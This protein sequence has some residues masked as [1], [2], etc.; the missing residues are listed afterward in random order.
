MTF[1]VIH[2]TDRWTERQTKIETKRETWRH[3]ETDRQITFFNEDPILA[4]NRKNVLF[5]DRVL[6]QS[7]RSNRYARILGSFLK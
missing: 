3:R 1:T 5:I 6:I 7:F 4:Y 2:Q